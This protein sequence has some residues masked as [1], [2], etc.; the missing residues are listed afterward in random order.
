[1]FSVHSI[2]IIRAGI[3]GNERQKRQRPFPTPDHLA[4]LWPMT[5]IDPLGSGRAADGFRYGVV[6]V[7]LRE[8]KYL[9]IRRSRFVSAPGSI[10]FPGGGIEAG[11][12]ESGAVIRE[13]REELG[14]QIIQPKRLLWRSIT[15]RQVRLAWW[16]VEAPD[17]MIVPDRMEV[18]S[19]DWRT[20]N[21]L[22]AA[23]DLLDSNRAFF[24]AMQEGAFE[25]P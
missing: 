15:P 13:L 24:R 21:E 2:Q 4:I 18:D 17:Q 23:N 9:T 20:A 14:M 12:S 5:P 1:M 11:E 8:K 6:A 25:L 19:F 3:I 22:L 7:I 10:C 16:L